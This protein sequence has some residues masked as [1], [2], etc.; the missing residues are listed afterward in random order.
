[1]LRFLKDYSQ[2]VKTAETELQQS[3]LEVQKKWK[4]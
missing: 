3:T 4:Y 2:E 1:M